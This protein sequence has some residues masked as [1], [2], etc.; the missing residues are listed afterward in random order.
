MVTGIKLLDTRNIGFDPHDHHDD[1]SA[2][3]NDDHHDYDSAAGHHADH[4]SG[5]GLNHNQCA[6][7][8][9][10]EYVWRDGDGRRR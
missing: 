3:S 8:L 9:G 1:D 6:H 10:G 7:P 4:Y 2:A 5:T